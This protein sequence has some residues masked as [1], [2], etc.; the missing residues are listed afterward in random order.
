MPGSP[1]LRF[2]VC[3][4]TRNPGADA[5]GQASALIRQTLQPDAVLVID[6]S[7]TDDSLGPYAELGALIKVIDPA[8]FNHGATRQQGVELLKTDVIVF[9][10][11][12]A[13]LAEPVALQRLLDCF[14]DPAIGAAYGRQL[15][16]SGAGP[17]EAHARLFNYPAL[18]RTKTLEDRA[19]LGIKTVFIS[20]SFAA[21]RRSDLMA[22]GGFPSNLIMGE[23]TCVAA[24]M[25]MAGK[26]M[27][28]CADALVFHS[29]D[30][31]WA[32]EFRRYF[33]IGV[34]HVREPWIRQ[35]FGG[36]EGEGLR[37]LTSEV[38]YLLGKNPLLL[39]SAMIRSA[40]KLSG[41]RLGLRESSLPLG[42]K[43]HL[44]MFRSFWRA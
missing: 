10:T 28:Y 39:P 9:L 17:I 8:T 23:D 11:Q 29:H 19:T 2:A 12:D 40:L 27:G 7:S 20:N 30:Y 6:S 34:L 15:P 37:F 3:I 22:V 32:E 4:P 1:R 42:L 25:L 26:K 35:Q 24:K 14:E 5:A 21:Y 16:R 43:R 18:G 31:S 13:I 33:D 41:F 44:S 36:P 38:R